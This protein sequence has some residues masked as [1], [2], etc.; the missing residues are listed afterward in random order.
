MRELE[1]VVVVMSWCVCACACA[2]PLERE[3]DLLL[4]CFVSAPCFDSLCVCMGVFVES[5]AI[6]KARCQVNVSVCIYLCLSF[7][8]VCV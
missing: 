8:H 5:D 4:K 6:I 7:M 1:G 2:W 3:A